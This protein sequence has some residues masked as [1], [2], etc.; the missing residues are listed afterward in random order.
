MLLVNKN[1]KTKIIYIF[2]LF[3]CIIDNKNI[4]DNKCFHI[5]V[6][7]SKKTTKKS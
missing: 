4:A 6:I 2:N 7:R 1:K 3:Q 5:P